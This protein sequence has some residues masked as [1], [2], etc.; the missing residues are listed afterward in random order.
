[1][2]AT[3]AG[4][5]RDNRGTNHFD[6]GGPSSGE[7]RSSRPSPN[8]GGSSSI[9]VARNGWGGGLVPFITRAAY[10]ATGSVGYALIYP[11]AGGLLGAQPIPDP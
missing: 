5:V 10:Q 7:Y 9:T 3:E 6:F 8:R 4:V 11:I 2:A 1:M